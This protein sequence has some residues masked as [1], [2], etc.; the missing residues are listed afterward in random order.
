MLLAAPAPHDEAAALIRGKLPATRRLFDA[1][2]PELQA[3]AVVITGVED[4]HAIERVRNLVAGIPEGEDWDDAKREIAAE[5]DAWLDDEEASERRAELILRSHGYAAYAKSNWAAL[6]E[7]Q[8][9]FPWRKYQTAQDE[10]VRGTHAALDGLIA[11]ADS[12]FWRSHT[13]PWEFGCRCDV[14]GLTNA[15]VKDLRKAD[16]RN[17]D[18]KPAM[19]FVD[20]G[21]ELE[22]LELGHLYRDG[23]MNFV[24]RNPDGFKFDP[25]GGIVTLDMLK[26]LR[27][28]VGPKLW[29]GFADWA[30]NAAVPG[31]G[32]AWDYLTKPP[33]RRKAAIVPPPVVPPAPPSSSPATQPP[34]PV[35]PVPPTP[36]PAATP[37]PVPA[38]APKMSKVEKVREQ[39]RTAA[40]KTEQG[41]G[42]TAKGNANT[43]AILRNG[44]HVVF[45][46]KSGEYPREIR[47]GIKARTQYKR[48]IAASI[49]DEYLGTGMVPPVAEI[50]WK[51]DV[52]SAMLFQVGLTE[53]QVPPNYLKY[54]GHAFPRSLRERWQLFDDVVGHLD[55]HGGNWLTDGKAVS[56]IDN[57]LCLSEIPVY[58]ISGSWTRFPGPLDQEPLSAKSAKRLNDFKSKR[59]EIDAK[60]APLISQPAIDS[61]WLRVET[62]LRTNKHGL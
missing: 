42:S 49:I 16:L 19:K 23:V 1:M 56:L 58:N 15:D 11:P 48:E 7:Q 30:R 29:D 47:P 53:G 4:L 60:L 26:G 14:V 28:R 54:A 17:P 18:G 3:A 20:R 34:T 22:A 24:A 43:S 31:Q 25:E 8:Y 6:E 5:I 21:P 41:L 12:P 52:G 33:R 62:M 51:G 50:T 32:S 46:S 39:I 57:G 37:S 13:P 9:I 35:V 61:M 38:P 2:A 45:K 59:A 40:Y 36:A 44:V 27:K 55:R 10:R